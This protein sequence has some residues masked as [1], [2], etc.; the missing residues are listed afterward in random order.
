MRR[1]KAREES[2]RGG[3]AGPSNQPPVSVRALHVPCPRHMQLNCRRGLKK[4][5]NLICSVYPDIFFQLAVDQVLQEGDG[6]ENSVK[7]LLDKVK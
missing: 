6:N 3:Q 7:N 5:E 2:S 1:Y 4:E